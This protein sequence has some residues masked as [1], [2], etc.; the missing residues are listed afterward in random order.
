MSKYA[1][2]FLLDNTT[3]ITDK[4]KSFTI[5][6]SLDAFCRE[7]SFDLL[8]EDFYDALD[9]SIIPETPR[10]EVFTSINTPVLTGNLFVL[11]FE[12]VDGATFWEEEIFDLEPTYAENAELDT[13][14][15]YDGTSCL[16]LVG[17]VDEWAEVDYDFGTSPVNFVFSQRFRYTAGVVYFETY[18]SGASSGIGIYTW[19]NVLYIFAIDRLGNVLIDEEISSPAPDTWHEFKVTVSGRNISIEVNGIEVGSATASIAY[20]FNDLADIYWGSQGNV[21]ADSWVDKVYMST[22]DIIEGT[23]V[24]ISQGLYFIERPTFQIGT[25]ETTTGVWGRQSTAILGEPFA[26]KVTKLWDADTTFYAICQEIIESVGLVWDST[27]CDIQDFS[28]YADNFEA[29]DQYPIETLQ[30]LVELIVGEEGF[31][32][33]DR[34][35]NICIKRLERAPTTSD[36][37][38]TDL[39]I[40]SIN[41][42]PEW[43]EFGNRIKI[44]PVES[45][46]QN[47]ISVKLGSECIGISTLKVGYVD[48]WAQVKNGEGVPLN[49]QVV[50]WSFDP[51]VPT[52]L[53]YVYSLIQNSAEMLISK[54]IVRADSLV[55]LS[56]NFEA[57]SIIG[58]WAYADTSRANNFVANGAYILDGKKVYLTESNFNYCDQMVVVSY[59]VSGMVHN[60]VK[61]TPA[62]AL[63]YSGEVSIIASLSGKEDSKTIY[64]NNYCKCPSTLSAEI[65]P[66]TLEIGEIATITA[67]LENG[68]EAVSGVIYMYEY[69][70]LGTLSAAVL[71]T[72]S[73]TV[74]N[75]KAEAVN[76]IAGVTQCVTNSAI[77]SITGV[78]TYTEDSDGVITHV[79]GNLY[80]SFLNKTI[81]LNTILP[82]GTPLV[83]TYQRAGSVVNYFTAVTAGDVRITVS[84]P[85]NTEEG[86]SQVLTATINEAEEET[87]DEPTTVTGE[88]ADTYYVTGPSSLIF[89]KTFACYDNHQTGGTF[90]MHGLP[91]CY[92]KFGAWY[93]KKK[94]DNSIVGGAQLSH[95]GIGF[96]IVQNY[97]LEA[98]AWKTP[99]Q[100]FTITLNGPAGET[101]QLNVTL[102]VN[103]P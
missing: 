35:G 47:S 70:G 15:H 34:E 6:S 17:T 76:V 22:T 75:E 24:W 56:T 63:E 50:T 48:V 99:A 101:A 11:N 74:T 59:V 57:S 102:S 52:T 41:E 72:G 90:N 61:Y 14:Q 31:V 58:I 82:T 93:L 100:N 23:T 54:E 96:S 8:D 28:I 40:Q 5:E 92:Q 25:H 27:K 4:I 1:F 29:D 9:F 85:V 38:L 64:V 79:S 97:F 13:A 53:S 21:G 62:G 39:I 65:D 18:M 16:K 98:C 12:G 78:Y 37:N 66:S 7:L 103:E 46:S 49:D 77:S 26:Q 73:V 88:T 32:T 67:Y 51:A 3:D 95:T 60:V 55:A 94:S 33:S 84:S 19:E 80:S 86:L 20:P 10:I 36:F 87:V 42:E 2:K 68:D 69:T 71:R 45:V 81:N 30:T 83:V 89:R 43:P 44:I 91:D